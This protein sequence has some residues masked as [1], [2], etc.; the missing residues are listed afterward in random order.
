MKWLLG[1]LATLGSL[2]AIFAGNNKKQKIKKIKTN[3][4][5]QVNNRKILL[6]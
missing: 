1:I 2:L 3:I 4:K 5:K 6:Y